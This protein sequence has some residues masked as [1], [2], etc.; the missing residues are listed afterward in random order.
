MAVTNRPVNNALFKAEDTESL[1]SWP[2]A[3]FELAQVP[4]SDAEGGGGVFQ[5]PVL[6]DGAVHGAL[7]GGHGGKLAEFCENVNFR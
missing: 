3:A 7:D 5:C 1:G 4:D 2:L 6:F